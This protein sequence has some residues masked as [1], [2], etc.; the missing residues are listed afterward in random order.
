MCGM[1][2]VLS[3]IAVHLVAWSALGRGWRAAARAPFVVFPPVAALLTLDAVINDSFANLPLKIATFAAWQALCFFGY[4]CLRI[5]L[6]PAAPAR[7]A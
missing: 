3:F 6:R 5:L 7:R 4:V 2:M 1:A